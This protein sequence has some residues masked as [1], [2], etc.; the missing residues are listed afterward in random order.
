MEGFLNRNRIDYIFYHL[1]LF[2]DFNETIRSKIKFIHDEGSVDNSEANIYFLLT[3]HPYNE[4]EIIHIDNI[5]VLFTCSAAP[6]FYTL[7]GPSL[8]FNHDLLKSSFY[9][10]SGYQ[11]YTP[12]KWEQSGRFPYEKS[13]Q[14]KL[15]I[16]GKPV[17]NY[18]F[19][20][21]KQGIK[22]FCEANKIH[23]SEKRLFKNFGFLLTHDIDRIEAY[24]FWETGYRLKKFLGLAPRYYSR[25]TA[26]KEFFTSAINYIN[27][28]NPKNPFWNFIFLRAIE[29]D[30]SIRSVFYF[31]EDE[32][33]HKDSHY[34]FNDK[35]IK[36]LIAALEKDGCEIGLHGTTNSAHKIESL[37]STLKNLQSVSTQKIPGIRQHCLNYYLPHTALLHEKAGLK[38]DSTLTFAEHEGFRNSCCTPFKLYDFENERIINVWEFS[39]TIMDGTLLYYRKLSFEEIVKTTAS[40]IEEI[41]RFN[42]L[43]VLLWHNTMFDE[44]EFSGISDFYRQYIREICSSEPESVTGIELLDR[45]SDPQ[46]S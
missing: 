40:I 34:N 36:E 27:F 32:T 8:V 20:I 9:L 31:L 24:D 5:P 6:D 45:L 35:R 44:K 14:S 19:D 15:D 18:Y 26:L 38:Y 33:L 17:V 37:N 39:L 7:T 41:K 46:Y 16:T 13:V 42:G 29:K 22:V 43:L 10:L 30:N 1:N 4:N 23:F 3:D 28:I 21:I 2:F 11:E 25:R 12:I